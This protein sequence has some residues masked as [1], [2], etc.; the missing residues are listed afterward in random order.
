MTTAGE[1]AAAAAAGAAGAAA[2]AAAEEAELQAAEVLLE[3]G[4]CTSVQ[5]STSVQKSYCV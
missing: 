2:A 1:V 4:K 3:Q 5:R